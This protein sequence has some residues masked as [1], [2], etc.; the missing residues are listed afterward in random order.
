VVWANWYRFRPG[1]HIHHDHVVSVSFVWV[2]Q[3]SGVIATGGD[4]FRLTTNSILRLPWRH[5]VGYRSDERSP[6]QV[7]TIH[8]V[9]WHDAAVPVTPRVAFA[10]DDP[11]LDAEFRRGDGR[12]VS[13]AQRQRA[14]QMSSRS[15]TGRNVISLATYAV[16][17]FLAAP[18]SETTFRALGTLILDES[19]AWGTHGPG[20]QATPPVTLE[21]MTDHIVDNI[22]RHLT[23][24]EIAG[25]GGCSVSTAERLFTK[26]TGMSVLGWARTTRMR[27]AAL[28]LRTTGLRASEVARRVGFSDPLYFSRVFRATYAVP[29]S[30]YAAGQLRP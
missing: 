6:F 28:L 23:V 17:R 26:Y 29:P 8:V 20:A 10:S 24:A 13:P 25:V 2:L 1:E 27:Q 15:S 7:G 14:V 30:R 3:G 11:L 4:E 12:S 19:A 18:F 5:E 21:L 16:E 9:P 22:A